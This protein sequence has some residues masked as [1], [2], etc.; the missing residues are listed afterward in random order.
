MLTGDGRL[1]VSYQLSASDE[2]PIASFQWLLV[3]GD[4]LLVT[5]EFRD[6]PKSEPQ[7]TGP[8]EPPPEAA[9]WLRAGD[10]VEHH[11]ANAGA[12]L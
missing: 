5:G 7:L 3:T 2:V 10:E 4:W 6:Q 11:A 8:E 9:V 1:S 12:G